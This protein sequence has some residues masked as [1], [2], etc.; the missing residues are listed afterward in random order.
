MRRLLLPSRPPVGGEHGSSWRLHPVYLLRWVYLGRMALVFGILLGAFLAWGAAD[1]EQTFV[2][3]V[4]FLAALAI[5][6][7]GV[8]RTHVRKQIPGRG[9]LFTQMAFD[10][11][12]VTAMVHV[13]GGAGSMFAAL[14]IPVIGVSAVVLPGAGVGLIGG[15]SAILYLA[16]STWAHQVDLLSGPVLPQIGLFFVVAVIAGF[17]GDRLRRT[18]TAL[19]EVERELRRLRLDTSDILASVTSGI[20]TVDQD[21]RLVYL[22]PAGESLLGLDA[23]EWSEE[24]ILDEVGRVAPSLGALFRRSLAEGVSLY[25]RTAEA[26]RDHETIVLG[27]SITVRDAEGQP[28]AVTGVFQDITDQERLKLLNRQNERL[29]A[30]AELAASMAHEIKNPLASIRSAVEQYTSP[31]ITDDDRSSLS[32]MITRESERLSRLLADFIDFTRVRVHTRERVDLREIVSDA[33]CVARQH[34]D[35]ERRTVGV[36]VRLPDAP[37][38]VDADADVLHRA[39]MNL[40]LNAAQF[41]PDGGTVEVALEDLRGRRAGA[42]RR[43]TGLPLH[44]VGV[45]QPVRVRVRDHGPGIPKDQLDRLFD[46]FFTTRK[47]GSGLGLAMVHRAVEAHR[48]AVVVEEPPGDGAEFILYLP[49]ESM[50]ESAVSEPQTQEAVTAGAPDG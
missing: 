14:Y 13:S 39:I 44:K 49:G 18:D 19:A 37:V 25:R 23:R 17:L 42:V 47:E 3:T 33:V 28:R 34:P 46:P 35:A 38:H 12:A 32:R 21:G 4:L 7:W 50:E 36:D 9:F 16:D 26:V 43:E 11:L 1:P 41:S 22:N 10:A 31:R 8:W 6:A 48:G 15:L 20:L 24:P 27:V 29:G 45:E 2:V 30:V 40:T 5:T